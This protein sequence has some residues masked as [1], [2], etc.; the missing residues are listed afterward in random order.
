MLRLPVIIQPSSLDSRSSHRLG[1]HGITA[2][3][4]YLDQ[5][6]RHSSHA[7]DEHHRQLD[8]QVNS[9]VGELAKQ[10]LQNRGNRVAGT[11]VTPRTCRGRPYRVARA[12]DDGQLMELCPG[13][14]DLSTQ[15]VTMVDSKISPA[16]DIRLG[17]RSLSRRRIVN[18]PRSSCK[19]RLQKWDHPPSNPAHQHAISKSLKYFGMKNPDLLLAH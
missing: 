13:S 14:S 7:A 5:I 11:R 18:A 8:Y 16:R 12:T 19:T 15:A 2:T 10:S 3:D 17:C 6:G 1:W 9:A 4:Y